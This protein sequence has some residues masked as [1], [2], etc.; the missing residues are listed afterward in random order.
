MSKIIEKNI[1]KNP[2]TNNAMLP[3]TSIDQVLTE[4]GTAKIEDI[5]IFVSDDSSTTTI[6][7]Q[8]PVYQSDITS[9]T[10][11]TSE[12]QVANAKVIKTLNDKIESNKSQTDSDIQT[13][14]TTLNAKADKTEIPNV[15]NFIT[16]S[17]NDLVNYYKK[18]ETYTQAEVNALVSAIPKFAIQVVSALPT[19]GISNTTIYLVTTGS[20]TDNLYTEYIYV[21]NKWEK[22]GTQ[23]V[24]LSGYVE[25]S[26]IENSITTKEINGVQNTIDIN[27]TYVNIN[28]GYEATFTNDVVVEGTLYVGNEHTELEDFLN[29]KISK[30]SD[31]Y[32]EDG[33][34]INFKKGNKVSH[35]NGDDLLLKRN[36]SMSSQITT[37]TCD[38]IEITDDDEGNYRSFL[39]S[40]GLTVNNENIINKI[41]NKVDKVAGKGL[42]TN[43]Y[44]TT[45]KNKL[46]SLENYDDSNNVFVSNDTTTGQIEA[47]ILLLQSD[48]VNNVTTNSE[49]RP[50]SA[51]MGLFLMNE[52]NKLKAEIS[53]L[54]GN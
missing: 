22:L 37:I 21:N 33:V 50:L 43:D 16:K 31:T 11:S 23:K 13:I 10:T 9:S 18:T 20:E 46:T 14:N 41:N 7:N 2:E 26:D 42:S 35:I 54:K 47:P 12:T 5:M 45:E 52:I 34:T 8:V 30:V 48:V 29:E 27:A 6:A 28:A 40:R 49:T 39:S 38:G 3:L 15:S 36:T 32:T 17:V 4:D 44:T 53:A 19:T 51:N 1:L 24:D 25:K